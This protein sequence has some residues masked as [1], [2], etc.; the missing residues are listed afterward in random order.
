M[1]QRQMS[2]PVFALYASMC[3]R[4]GESPP[5]M[6]VRMTP[7]AYT[8]NGRLIAC[9]FFPYVPTEATF[10]VQTACPVF[11]L[12]AVIEPSA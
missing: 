11:V 8:V 5:L 3:P 1:N 6:P 12:T 2:L 10:A 7:L 9:D 4:K